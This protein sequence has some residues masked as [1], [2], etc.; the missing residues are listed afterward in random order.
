MKILI[1]IFW[2]MLSGFGMPHSHTEN[3]HLLHVKIQ[4]VRQ[5]KGDMLLAIYSKSE[6]FP[7]NHEK[8]QYKILEKVTG[9]NMEIAVELPAGEYAVALLHDLNQNG[10]L[11]LNLLG[12][13]TEPFGFS[14]NPKIMFGPPSFKEAA[15]K[16]QGSMHLEI[17]LR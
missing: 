11:D 12:I 2:V 8:S 9:K 10:E 15:V 6:G 7:S 5:A 4:N 3:K 16:L 1:C 17:Q 14:N 13:P